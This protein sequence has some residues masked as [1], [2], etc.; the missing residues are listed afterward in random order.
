MTARPKKEAAAPATPV[1]PVKIINLESYYVKA[2]EVYPEVYVV[3][4]ALMLLYSE[5]KVLHTFV[6][7]GVVK[8]IVEA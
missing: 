6:R 2:K 1:S 5:N 7:K 3:D 8:C 4:A